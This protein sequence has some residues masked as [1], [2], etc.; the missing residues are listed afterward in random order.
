MVPFGFR[1][2]E[3]GAGTVPLMILAFVV[4]GA[5]F[6]WLYFQAS[7]VEVLVIEGPGDEE[8]QVARIITIEVFADD[9]MAQ[10]GL[11][12]Q[13]HTLGVQSRVGSGA[14]FV[15]L[16]PATNYLVRMLPEVVADSLDLAT[17]TTVSVTG[18]VYAMTDSVAD[19]WVASGVIADSDR[20]LAI[21]AESFLEA[22]AVRVTAPPQP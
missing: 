16:P 21:F 8:Q 14:F 7:P 9:P 6:T 15:G 11:H 3:A 22:R 5:F 1:K 10:A 17:N 18:T 12:I 2:G 4:A 19:S 13:V 20:V